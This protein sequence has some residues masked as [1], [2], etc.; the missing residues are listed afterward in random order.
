MEISVSINSSEYV[1]VFEP[2]E[3]LEKEHQWMGVIKEK[4]LQD[5]HINIVEVDSGFK[6]LAKDPRIENDD[7]NIQ[8]QLDALALQVFESELDGVE[9]TVDSL[10]PPQWH[11][12]PY[13]PE[14]IR[15]EPHNFSL[16]QIYEMLTGEFKDIDLTPDFQRNFVWTDITRKSRLI[17]S[18]LLRIPLPVFYLS[19]NKD[20]KLNVVDGVQRLTVIKQFMNNEFRLKNLEYL[21]QFNGCYYKKGNENERLSPKYVRRLL[22]TQ[23]I[24]NIIDPSSPAKVKYDIFKRINTGGKP[25]N[26]MEI[27]N[28]MANNSTRSLL[29]E[30]AHSS[31][32]EKVTGGINDNRFIGQEL[33]LR[34]IAF[35]FSEKR[36]PEK[37]KYSGD[38]ESYLDETLETLNECSENEIVRLKIAFNNA[39]LNAAHLFGPYAFR[40][41]LPEHL[42]SYS[43]KQLINKSLFTTWT[44]QLSELKPEFVKNKYKNGEMAIKVAKELDKRQAYYYAVTLGTNDKER[45]QVAFNTAAELLRS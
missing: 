29:K 15:V 30:L 32:L 42:Y 10:L 37:F 35:Y 31:E 11:I 18:I 8:Q 22:Q 27:R 43:R 7:D 6:L 28:C 38:M 9:N 39:I 19:Q 33:I 16:H 14:E 21:L 36:N 41:C 44:V 1:M 26:K 23:I 5:V 40:K 25:L 20:G 2:I 34:F 45:L 4:G 17:E 24:A 12:K 3:P 13:D